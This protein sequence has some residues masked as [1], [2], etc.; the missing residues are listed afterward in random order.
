MPIVRRG[1]AAL[2]LLLV[3]LTVVVVGVRAAGSG[4]QDDEPGAAAT[5]AA[6]PAAAGEPASPVV[7][8][9]AATAPDATAAAVPAVPTLTPLGQNAFGGAGFNA[10]ARALGGYAYVGSWGSGRLCP[11]LGVRVVDLA[12]P[13][14]PAWVATAARYDGTSAEDVQPLHVDTPF[15]RGDLLAAGIQRCAG[16]SGL[17]GGLALW[18]IT[19]PRDPQQL[20]FFL[21]GVGPRG[22]H[23]LDVTVQNG[24]VLAL[25]AVPYSQSSGQ[26]DFRI[27]DITDPRR[28]VQLYA[29]DIHR[30]LGF[31]P[32][33]GCTQ[34]VYD[35]SVRAAAGGAR[36]YLSYWDAGVIILDISD[37]AAPRF[38]GRAI[39]PGA[40]GAIHS[41]D[42][43]AGDLLLVTEED[44]VFETPHGLRLRV[45]AD[46]AAEE[47]AA[48]EA[49]SN[50]RLDATGTLT[51]TLTDLGTLCGA[52]PAGAMGTIAVVEPGGCSL[53]AKA[54]RARAGGVQALILIE[55]G[56]LATPAAEIG[57]GLPVVGVG[58]AD[59]DRLRALAQDGR[60]GAVLPAARPWGG[61][62]V[63]D[64]RDPANP[65]PRALFRTE[66]ARRFPPLSPGYYTVHNPLSVGRYALFSW[67]ADGV[68]LVDLSDPD[69]PQEVTSA[70]FVPPMAADPF[71]LFPTDALVWGVALAGDLVLASDINGG[72]YV[73]RAE[74]LPGRE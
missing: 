73:L 11:A 51:G 32:G 15:F 65:Q 63:W 47:F 37:P 28:P 23:E 4:G 61:V 59:G 41:V 29:W 44:D 2:L 50:V 25:L 16:G 46:G 62:Q 6:G 26:G 69:H 74:G 57:L 34:E 17:S 9:A 27:V 35:H 13:A 53:G 3:L 56:A 33:T 64:I 20:S 60:A 14:N 10:N 68:R 18:D 70:A 8:Q 21:T 48:C 45:E 12:D 42:E 66:N 55:S 31:T 43:M 24:R 5:P 38:L 54:Q 49:N 72:L 67:Y 58:V 39:W 52:A 36:A 1:P 71:G 7:A 40:E 22:V 19:D 30:E